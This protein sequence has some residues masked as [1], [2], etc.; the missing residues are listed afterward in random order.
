MKYPKTKSCLVGAPLSSFLFCFPSVSGVLEKLEERERNG[1]IMKKCSPRG[2]LQI[3]GE[4]R[5]EEESKRN[6]V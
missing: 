4:R 3:P 1:E 6:I 5:L 2:D